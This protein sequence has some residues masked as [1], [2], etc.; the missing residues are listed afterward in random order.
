MKLLF[1]EIRIVEYQELFMD[2]P[3]KVNILM[4]NCFY[5]Q[6][7]KAASPEQVNHGQLAATST[8]FQGNHHRLP[9]QG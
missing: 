2:Q 7:W 6:R 4:K 1:L 8:L 9:C 5:P 3:N